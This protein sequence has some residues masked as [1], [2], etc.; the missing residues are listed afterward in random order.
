MI[1]A[2]GLPQFTEGHAAEICELSLDLISEALTFKTPLAPLLSLNLKI[3]IHSG[4]LIIAI[5]FRYT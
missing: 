4:K 2:S 3:S 5:V 1:V